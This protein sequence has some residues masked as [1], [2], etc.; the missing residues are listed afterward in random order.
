MS[1]EFAQIESVR[2]GPFKFGNRL[3]PGG[4]SVD[5]EQSIIGIENH[6]DAFVDVLCEEFGPA[7]FEF[8][9][10]SVHDVVAAGNNSN[11]AALKGSDLVTAHLETVQQWRMR[12]FSGASVHL[13]V[14]KT[15]DPDDT[16]DG[17]APPATLVIKGTASRQ[18]RLDKK[19][20]NLSAAELMIEVAAKHKRR[21]PLKVLKGLQPGASATVAI[22]M[23]Q[24]PEELQLPK[25]HEWYRKHWGVS[26]KVCM[27]M[28]QIVKVSLAPL[29]AQGL[30]SLLSPSTAGTAPVPLH[31]VSDLLPPGPLCGDYG[32]PAGCQ[33]SAVDIRFIG[34]PVF[35][36]EKYHLNY[37]VM[38][39][40]EEVR[41]EVAW[42]QVAFVH[43]SSRESQP[44]CQVLACLRF[45]K[46]IT[47][48]KPII[49]GNRNKS[50]L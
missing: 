21:L 14:E 27:S 40:D 19:T 43:P 46:P 8:G 3:K 33:L 7:W 49:F 37:T 12:E 13:W 26:K 9:Q 44:C 1:H 38:A 6:L 29:A 28:S 16:E 31:P 18:A 34:S 50:K 10:I 24:A 5:A 47:A 39:V 4:C 23:L 32:A 35:I 25:K 11:V 17:S 45:V 22:P 2:S 42:V 15:M 20:L 41:H 30:A 48:R 36:G